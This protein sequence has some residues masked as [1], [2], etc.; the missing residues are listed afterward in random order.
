[1]IQLNVYFK[2][3]NAKFM[4]VSEEVKAL[5]Q[6]SGKLCKAEAAVDESL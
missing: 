6:G 2:A 4:F 1:M 5:E 3:T